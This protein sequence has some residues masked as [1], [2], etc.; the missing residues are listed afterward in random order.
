VLEDL[1]RGAL[2]DAQARE[3]HEPIEHVLARARAAKPVRDLS[4][5]VP[6]DQIHLIAEIKRESPSK[7]PLAEIP[8]PVLLARAYENGGASAISVVTES[9]RFGGSLGDLAAVSE[10]VNIPVLRKDFIH[11]E[12]QIAEARANGADLVLLIM[13]GLTDDEA[14]HLLRYTRALGMEALVET[15][16]EA[17]LT[18][19]IGLEARIIGINARD[20]GT[21]ELDTE[22]FGMLQGLIPPGI[23]KVAE[24]AVAHPQDVTRYREQGAHA[25]LVGEA[26]V[27]GTNPE[28]QVKEFVTA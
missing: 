7:G 23:L 25:V 4:V 3:A 27:T 9:R 28:A 18:R 19:A 20:L 6:R 2:E 13:A 10:A 8:D 22:L 5:L 14:T 21:F 17:E 15:H 1:F 26:L 16:S 11:T 24:S 12:Y